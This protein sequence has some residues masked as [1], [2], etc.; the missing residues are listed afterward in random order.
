[1]G[2]MKHLKKVEG[3]GGKKHTDSA[4]FFTTGRG[5]RRSVQKR[6]SLSRLNYQK[7]VIEKREKDCRDFNNSRAHSLQFGKGETHKY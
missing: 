1:V 7:N 2:I 6:Q 3:L 5:G 4:R